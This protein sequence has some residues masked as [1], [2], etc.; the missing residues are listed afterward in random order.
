MSFIFSVAE[1]ADMIYVY[2]FCEGN[3]I[4]AVAKYQRRF[5]NRWIPTR[6]VFTRVYQTLRDPGTLPG[7]RIAA[8]SDVNE[9]VDEEEGIVQ[10]YRAVHVRVRIDLQ[11]VFVFPTREFGEN[12]FQ[13]ACIRTTCSVCNVSELA[14]L[15]R[16]WKYASGPMAVAS[17][18]VTSCLLTKRN[19]IA[20]VSVTHN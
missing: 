11:N 19:S 5:P 20:T 1:Y 9:G 15:H 6:R 7:V 14:I 2:G 16:G 13:K 4:H 17:C 8:E 12:C 3:S 10:R 18:I